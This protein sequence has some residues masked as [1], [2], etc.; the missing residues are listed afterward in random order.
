MAG[1]DR[2]S[3]DPVCI[4]QHRLYGLDSLS[5]GFAGTAGELNV[6]D[7]HM[8]AFFEF[9]IFNQAVDEID[10]TSKPDQKDSAKVGMTGITRQRTLKNVKTFALTR[11]SWGQTLNCELRPL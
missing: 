6:K 1:R 8:G 2:L 4:G 11:R 10:L 9:H 7:T 5:H 3:G